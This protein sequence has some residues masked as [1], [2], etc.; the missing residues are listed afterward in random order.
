LQQAR[1]VGTFALGA[2]IA[3]LLR[4][5]PMRTHV[6]HAAVF[7]CL[8]MTLP[9]PAAG[10]VGQQR[11]QEFFKE[12]QGRRNLRCGHRAA[13]SRIFAVEGVAP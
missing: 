3:I 7:R 8:L 1:S 10:Q 11:A 12:A 4:E 6:L 13:A 2:T 9:L 5:E